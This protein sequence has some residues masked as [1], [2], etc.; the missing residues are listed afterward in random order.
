MSQVSEAF[1]AWALSEL[2]MHYA[3]PCPDAVMNQLCDDT[4]ARAEALADLSAATADDLLLKLFPLLL[5]N[6]EPEGGAPPMLLEPDAANGSSSLVRSVIADLQRICPMIA[7]L[8]AAPH[9]K[10]PH[11]SS[12][13]FKGEA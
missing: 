9:F 11:R 1:R 4:S 5:A 7:Q 3:Q 6:F 8:M 13:D 12:F 10:C 2:A